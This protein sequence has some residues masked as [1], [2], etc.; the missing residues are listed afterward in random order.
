MGEWGRQMLQSLAGQ[1]RDNPGRPAQGSPKKHT[2]KSE[3]PLV[4]LSNLLPYFPP[5]SMAF[6]SHASTHH[7]CRW[8]PKL[9]GWKSWASPFPQLPRL[10]VLLRYSNASTSPSVPQSHRESPLF[11]ASA[12]GAKAKPQLKTSASEQTGLCRRGAG[13]R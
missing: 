13:A 5:R 10:M 8:L 11:T 12:V 4:F 9:K 1:H 2:C 3:F 6:L 7:C